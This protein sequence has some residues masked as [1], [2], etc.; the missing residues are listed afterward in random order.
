[1]QQS[2]VQ[3]VGFPLLTHFPVSLSHVENIETTSVPE[4]EE[5]Q[6]VLVWQ[7]ASLVQL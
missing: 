5:T 6:G 1:M 4:H 7:E 3:G 2:L